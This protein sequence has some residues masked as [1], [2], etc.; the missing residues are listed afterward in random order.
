MAAQAY[1]REAI[2]LDGSHW[3]RTSCSLMGDYP[4]TDT[5]RVK[6]AH[7]H[8]KAHRPD[9]KQ[10]L[11]TLF[12]NR[13]G[14]PLFG[15]VESGQRSDKTLN[16]E[17]LHRLVKAMAPEP[18]AQLIYGADSALI[19]GP[20]LER[21]ACQQ[22]ALVSRCPESFGVV[23]QVKEQAWVQDAWTPLAKF[24]QRRDAAQYWASEHQAPIEERTYRLV[25]YR[26]SALDRKRG[27][28]L[29]REMGQSRKAMEA[30]AK[31]LGQQRFAC[32]QDATTA[33]SQWQKDW[34]HGWYFATATIRSETQYTWPGRP[35]KVP[36]IRPKA[37][38]SRSSWARCAKT[39]NSRNSNAAE[40][41]SLLPPCLRSACLPRNYCANINPK[42]AWNVIFTSS[43]IRGS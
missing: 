34:E 16:G 40:R 15:T 24:G 2:T 14:V 26:S 31:A 36:E 21:L 13:E 1:V 4:G 20:N 38:G 41:S 10:L 5:A 29:D 12:V 25:V 7:G 27:H 8:S 23:R 19:T 37:G 39:V 33:W 11:L 3:D 28:M 42:P 9:L 22:I 35:R 32:E 17:M 18:L 43:R 6:P 30:S